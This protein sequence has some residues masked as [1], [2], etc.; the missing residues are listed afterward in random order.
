MKNYN[1]DL[2]KYLA[3]KTRN[4]HKYLDIGYGDGNLFDEIIQ[5]RK[6][7][8]HIEVY[9]IEKGDSLKKISK[10]SFNYV[11]ML[12]V[13]EHLPESET[14]KYFKFINNHLFNEGKLIISTPNTKNIYQIHSFWDDKTHIRPFTDITIKQIAEEFGF[15]II[16]TEPFHYFK[17]PIKIII[18]KLLLLDDY[19]KKIYWLVKKEWVIMG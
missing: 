5:Q 9:G 12:D 11:F 1:Y 2:H 16:K 6:K 19:N 7:M 17:N 4:G 8:N 13:I 14:K 18:N 15:K 10:K 3:I